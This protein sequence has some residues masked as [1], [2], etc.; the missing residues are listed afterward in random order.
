[1][2]R[3]QHG[4]PAAVFFPFGHPTPYAYTLKRLSALC[5]ETTA[6]G[7]S[8]SARATPKLGAKADE[9]E[10]F[11]IR[12]EQENEKCDNRMQINIR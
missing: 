4:Q 3:M 11:S 6:P 8:A 1:M 5:L 12:E 2:D 9:A 10:T 7:N